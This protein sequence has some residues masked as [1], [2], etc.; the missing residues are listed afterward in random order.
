MPFLSRCPEGQCH[1]NRFEKR[2]EHL[3]ECD[4][5]AR[6]ITCFQAELRD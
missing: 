4:L 1:K 6:V 5:V 2:S 3:W